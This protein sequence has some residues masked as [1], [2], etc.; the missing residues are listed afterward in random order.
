MLKCL[1]MCV[2]LMKQMNIKKAIRPSINAQI[3]SLVSLSHAH[4]HTLT[5]KHSQL[6]RI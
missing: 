1:T 2:E 4:T 6:K 5:V 3:E